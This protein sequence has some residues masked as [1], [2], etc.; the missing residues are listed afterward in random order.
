MI[1][2][3]FYLISIFV[4]FSIFSSQ[5]IFS[6]NEKNIIAVNPVKFFVFYNLNYYRSISASSV[7]G[8]GAQIPTFKSAKGYG[9]Q[10][11]YRYHFGGRAP[12]GFYTAPNFSYNKIEIKNVAGEPISA[13][14]LFGWQW[15]FENNFAMGIGLGG[16]YYFLRSTIIER[17]FNLVNG[18]L[19]AI[20]FD[21][22]F[23]W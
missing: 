6:Q 20:R 15:M 3:Y 12:V 18:F 11:E 2:R 5:N 8:G 14:I 13:G 7:I 9:F 23:A 21:V 16:D 17:D 10:A 1:K 19:P 22:G 4:C